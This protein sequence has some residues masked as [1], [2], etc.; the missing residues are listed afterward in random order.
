MP[1]STN[2]RIGLAVQ[3]TSSY[4]ATYSF[5][6]SSS[7]GTFLTGGRDNTIYSLA[8]SSYAPDSNVL[9]ANDSANGNWIFN[10]DAF[11]R[12]VGANQNSGQAVYNYVY[13][14][15]GNRWQQNGPHTMTLAFTGNATTNNNRADGYSYDLAGNLLNDGTNTYTYDAESRIRTAGPLA[16]CMTRMATASGKQFRARP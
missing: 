10:Y 6:P 1:R 3:H 16:T 8:L 9:T 14:R 12:V 5:T 7:T 13:D 15:A 11:N 4:F 2:Y